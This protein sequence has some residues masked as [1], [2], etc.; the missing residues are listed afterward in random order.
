ME[1]QKAFQAALDEVNGKVAIV[2]IKRNY[3][4]ILVQ[5]FRIYNKFILPKSDVEY[6]IIE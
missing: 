6:L 5:Q 4:N 2:Q 1:F 3:F